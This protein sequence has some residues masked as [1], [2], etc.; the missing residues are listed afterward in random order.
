MWTT[1]D[2]WE[3]FSTVKLMSFLGSSMNDTAAPF[4]RNAP[5][6][7]TI[8]FDWTDI[9]TPVCRSSRP[10]EPYKTFIWMRRTLRT[11]GWFT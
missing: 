11:R 5:H 1:R 4:L 10:A 9:S 8:Y 2:T 6:V 7:E 3:S